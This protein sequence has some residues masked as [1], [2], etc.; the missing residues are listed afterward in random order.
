MKYP[1]PND[2]LLSNKE[3]H[4]FIYNTITNNLVFQKNKIADEIY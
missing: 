1:T 2:L 4:F 3:I